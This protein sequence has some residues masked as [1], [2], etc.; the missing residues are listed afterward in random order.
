MT[1]SEREATCNL[2][3]ETCIGRD[4]SLAR[5]F[6]NTLASLSDMLTSRE[7]KAIDVFSSYVDPSLLEIFYKHHHDRG[8]VQGH[9]HLAATAQV[10]IRAAA[11]NHLIH[12][13]VTSSGPLDLAVIPSLQPGQSLRAPDG[14]GTLP[15]QPC[16][17]AW[18]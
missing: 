6:L 10:H 12:V 2:A 16:W 5:P 17:Q 7:G 18:K 15:P 14:A 1:I 9:A 3:I 13:P 4:D 8:L 11:E